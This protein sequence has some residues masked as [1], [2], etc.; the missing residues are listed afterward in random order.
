MGSS[1]SSNHQKKVNECYPAKSGEIGPASGKISALTYYINARPE[2]LLKV[3]AYLEKKAKRDV[4]K[5]SSRFIF[6]LGLSVVIVVVL[7]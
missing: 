3:S 5:E 7:T 1:F 2:K 4:I 6:I